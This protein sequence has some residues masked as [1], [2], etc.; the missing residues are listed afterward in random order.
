MS[1][2]SDHKLFAFFAFGGSRV[3][4]DTQ[5]AEIGVPWLIVGYYSAK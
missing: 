4:W 2:E 3:P 5:C 1:E